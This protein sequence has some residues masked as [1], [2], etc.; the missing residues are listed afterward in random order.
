M[1]C[2]TPRETPRERDGMRCL[3]DRSCLAR[4]NTTLRHRKHDKYP[5]N[6]TRIDVV[7]SSY[8]K[9]NKERNAQLSHVLL[10]DTRNGA[11]CPQGKRKRR[12]KTAAAR[13]GEQR[14]MEASG[15]AV[16]QDAPPPPPP[17]PPSSC[18][19]HLNKKGER[20][21]GEQVDV[22]VTRFFDL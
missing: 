16:P 7:Q 2:C 4:R 14:C 11:H 13:S 3:C 6:K 8:E 20:N 22:F 15:E 18:C 9:K 21:E 5:Q 10:I 1:L 19:L 12:Q 17:S